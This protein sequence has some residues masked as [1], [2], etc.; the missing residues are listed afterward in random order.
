MSNP[1]L[2]ALDALEYAGQRIELLS[3]LFSSSRADSLEFSEDALC[4]LCQIIWGI[5]ELLSTAHDFLETSIH[6]RRPD[7]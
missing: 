3:I 6:E 4:G 7:V 1:C 2:S 5:Q